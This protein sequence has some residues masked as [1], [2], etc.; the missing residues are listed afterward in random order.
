MSEG[1][2][3]EMVVQ[4]RLFAVLRER[5]GADSLELSLGPEATVDDALASLR[6]RPPLDALLAELPVVMAVN[7]D[8][9]VGSTVLRAGDELALI[10]PVSG[11]AGV[12]VL[13][14][15]QPLDPARASRA[16]ADE[17]AGAIV[18]FQ[19]VTR[20]VPLLRYEAYAEMARGQIERI[21]GEALREFALCAVAVEHRIGDVALGEPSVLVAASSPHRGEAF[22]GARAVIDRVKAEAAIWKQEHAPDG[23]ARW[24][25]GSAAGA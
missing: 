24:V 21:A 8:Y 14:S 17:R 3:G 18:I 10:P 1:S 6:E 25:G 16:V 15:E 9:A 12:Q 5:V 22:A 23:V 2:P 4:V 7:R 19:G 20:E 11:G 13:L